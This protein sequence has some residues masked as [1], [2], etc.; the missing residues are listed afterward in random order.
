MNYDYPDGDQGCRG[1]PF[2]LSCA[3][4]LLRVVTVYSHCLLFYYFLGLSTRPDS[5]AVCATYQEGANVIIPP[6]ASWI[7]HAVQKSAN[8]LRAV[9][10]HPSHPAS[11]QALSRQG[12]TKNEKRITGYAADF[13]ILLFYAGMAFAYFVVF[14]IMFRLLRQRDP[15]GDDD[16]H[17]PV[18]GLRH[19]CTSPSSR[20]FRS[21]ATLAVW[22]GIVMSPPCARVE[23]MIVGLFLPSAWC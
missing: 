1:F 15:G 7:P 21:I 19:C 5:R 13:S 12:C 8:G 11:D 23:P 9:L 4:G 14:P 16:R 3:R 6:V 18:P 17:R 10:G 20:A 22:V 2:L